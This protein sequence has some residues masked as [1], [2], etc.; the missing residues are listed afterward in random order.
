M[1]FAALSRHANS[2]LRSPDRSRERLTLANS[3]VAPIGFSMKFRSAGLHGLNCH[4]HVGIAGDH[5]GRQPMA[6]IMEL[7]Q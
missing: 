3:S 7:Q 6:R 5:D 2:V 4:P 1:W